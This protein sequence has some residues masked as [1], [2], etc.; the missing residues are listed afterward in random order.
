MAGLSKE[1]QIERFNTIEAFSDAV[2]ALPIP[3]ELDTTEKQFS[4][5]IQRKSAEKISFAS[6]AFAPCRCERPASPDQA[7]DTRYICLTSQRQGLQRFIWGAQQEIVAPDELILWDSGQPMILENDTAAH[8]Y[9]FW[10]PLDRIERR[11][12]DIADYIGEKVSRVDPASRILRS[13]LEM[14][15]KEIDRLQ[16]PATA[17][18]L[19]ATIDLIF[20][21]FRARGA[22]ADIDS[23]KFGLMREAFAYIECAEDLAEVTPDTLAMHL[24]ISKR[25]IQHLF[26]ETGMTLSTYVGNVRLERAKNAL[27]SPHFRFYSITEIAHHFGFFDCSHFI[28]SFK[29]N[30]G[31]TPSQYRNRS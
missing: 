24:G 18:I 30:Y 9:N 12:G 11:V 8:A 15:Y 1:R 29:K 22:E 21:C 10:L 26:N 5:S 28:R 23:R 27:S 20:S 3:W 25:Y 31:L 13:H 4:A 2:R 16:S 19:D 6:V 17:K 7:K 14:I